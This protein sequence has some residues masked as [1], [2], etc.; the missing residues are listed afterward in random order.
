MPVSGFDEVA[1]AVFPSTLQKSLWI[2]RPS[3]GRKIEPD[4]KLR[5]RLAAGGIEH[6]AT[7]RS[8]RPELDE[9]FL[10]AIE[11]K[12]PLNDPRITRGPKVERA[13]GRQRIEL[14]TPAG[15][16]RAV[17]ADIVNAA[18][19]FALV[20]DPDAGDRLVGGIDHPAASAV[21]RLEL[22]GDFRRTVGRA[23][24]E[25]DGLRR[26]TLGPHNHE[27]PL[28]AREN[29]VEREPAGSIGGSFPPVVHVTPAVGH[30]G[31][32]NRFALLIGDESLNRA[33]FWPPLENQV[34]FDVAIAIGRQADV[35]LFV[36]VGFLAGVEFQWFAE[37]HE[38]E[39]K[40]SLGIAP[41]AIDRVA[42]FLL[43]TQTDP[44][45]DQRLAGLIFHRAVDIAP[46]AGRNSTPLVGSPGV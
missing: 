33:A 9:R 35:L 31:A 42:I 4:A 30:G 32:G 17:A 21:A 22:D 45:A 23:R 10:R 28:A 15:V 16:G 1:F 27:R 5:H 20:A 7:D 26:K 40:A 18:A 13:I 8:C 11:R 29:V 14:K 2:V 41:H 44:S 19:A 34:H 38:I 36:E 3:V 39:V 46:S 6:S 37:R 25:F 24:R 43:A 12:L